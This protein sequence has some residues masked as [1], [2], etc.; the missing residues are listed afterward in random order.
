MV[1]GASPLIIAFTQLSSCFPTV[2]LCGVQLQ[3][4]KEVPAHK[5]V[6]LLN[7]ATCCDDNKMQLL[8]FLYA[9]S[10]KTILWMWL[11]FEHRMPI[12]ILM[13]SQSHDK[14]C[15]TFSTK[16]G[17]TV[18]WQ[19][20]SICSVAIPL[21]SGSDEG[22]DTGGEGAVNSYYAICH[23]EIR[24]AKIALKLIHLKGFSEW[25]N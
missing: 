8:L 16:L 22:P 5:K 1:F 9:C 17:W 2:R 7:W 10:S 12:I 11:H 18:S 20:G 6:L 23:R 21:K 25:A 3:T 13:E 15:S 4:Q 24:D 19:K 14:T